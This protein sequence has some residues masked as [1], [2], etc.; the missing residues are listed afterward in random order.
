MSEHPGDARRYVLAWIALLGLAAAS[1]A[2]SGARLGHWGVPAAF[3]IAAVKGAVVLLV[4]MHFLR[5]RSAIRLAVLIGLL[6]FG[7]LVGFAT[8]DVTT[9]DRP[10]LIPPASVTTKGSSQ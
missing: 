4:F 7:L 3:A 5:A 9:R 1:Y 2:L 8:A 10:P 6:V